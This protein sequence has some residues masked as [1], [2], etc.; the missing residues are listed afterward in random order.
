MEEIAGQTLIRDDEV[1]LRMNFAERVQHVLLVVSFSL[2]VLTGLPLMF[3]ELR[4]FKS[5]FGF[6]KAFFYRGILHRTAAVILIVDIVWHTGYAVLTWRGRDNFKEM[7]PRLKDALD[8]VALFGYNVGLSRWLYRK[9][10]LR[11]FFDRH[12]FWRFE[13]PPEYGRYNFVEKLE[14]LSVAWGSFVMIISGFFMWNVD[15]SLKIFP[16]WV[17]D[18]FVIVHGYEAMLAFLAIIIWHMYNVHLNPEVFPM[19]KIWLNGKI[20]GHELKTLHALEYRKILAERQKAFEAGG[21]GP[22]PEAVPAP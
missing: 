18:I 15:L 11:K 1:F 20:T 13:N 3:Y 9:G 21:A 5:V 8:A 2:L 10:I 19:S 6:E 12:P 7:I 14:Y 17:H 22:A 4:V 16:L